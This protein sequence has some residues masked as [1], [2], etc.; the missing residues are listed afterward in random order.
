MVALL[1]DAGLIDAAIEGRG[2]VER[3][4]RAVAVLPALRLPGH[5][6]P[7]VLTSLTP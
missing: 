7:L 3:A 5:S 4:G 6:R 1:W 2:D